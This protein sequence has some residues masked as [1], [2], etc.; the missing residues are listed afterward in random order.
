[1]NN[2]KMIAIILFVFILIISVGI[3][4][5]Q[6]MNKTKT[7]KSYDTAEAYLKKYLKT[8]DIKTETP[9]KSTVALGGTTSLAEELPDISQYPLSVK[10]NGQINIEIFSSPEKGGEGVDGWLNEVAKEFNNSK[11][12]INGQSVTVS[13]R[14]IA[15]GAAVDYL[16]SGKYMPDGFTPSNELWVEMVKAKNVNLKQIDSKLIW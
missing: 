1:M 10:G 16:I 14:S 5:T 12:T 15:S 11:Q 7:E 9:V 2:K 4:L 3:M 13:I 6:N 8:I